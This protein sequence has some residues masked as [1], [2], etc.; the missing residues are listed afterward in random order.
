MFKK[1]VWIVGL[2]TVLAIMFIGCVDELPPPDGEMTEVISLAKVIAN[3]P[4]G[5]IEDWGSVFKDT[6]F[7][8][9]GN[10]TFTIITEG[11]VKKLKIDGM[12]NGWGEGIDIY[13]DS[14]EGNP[15]ADFIA[16]DK[17]Y[18]L[19]KIDP[20][21]NGLK[22]SNGGGKM[23]A[24]GWASGAAFDKTIELIPGNIA[25]IRGASPKAI[26][27]S[28]DAPDGDGRK[29]TI[30]LEELSVTGI[31][32]GTQDPL[33]DDFDIR[34]LIQEQYWADGVK[35]V[36]KKGKS[37]GDQTIWYE[38]IAP[39]VYPKS[40]TVP[41]ED[42]GSYKVTFEVAATKGWRSASF[43]EDGSIVMKMVVQKAKAFVDETPMNAYTAAKG[44]GWVNVGHADH[45]VSSKSYVFLW[46]CNSGNSTA[47]LTT[48]VPLAT[49]IALRNY[50]SDYQNGNTPRLA[51]VLPDGYAAY[52]FIKVTYEVIPTSLGDAVP[53]ST[54][55]IFDT[56]KFKA[57]GSYDSRA[58][59]PN[60]YPNL[61]AEAKDHGI[62]KV[63]GNTFLMTLPTEAGTKLATFSDQPHGGFCITKNHN[64]TG[65]LIR[66]IKVEC[67]YN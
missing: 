39:V 64:G 16:G 18:I 33:L 3:A 55:A 11:G 30:I 49:P 67:G 66:L 17:I 7:Q 60:S 46:N 63:S 10:P 6:P 43:G 27:I 24:D 62:T 28:Y 52:D 13:N 59:S 65:V 50:T 40:K 25:D 57:D 61:D 29:G 4:D 51:Y 41:Q 32:G 34:D 15:G 53:A 45:F 20:V 1:N 26:R 19:G 56:A 2:L 44:Y 36:P 21:G 31:R 8:K 37:T 23:K 38:G 48:A 22:V 14:Y 54:N 58:Y 5:E 9:C 35:F 47:Y 42:L 12:K